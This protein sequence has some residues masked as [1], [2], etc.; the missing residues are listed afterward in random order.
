MQREREGR[1]PIRER[2]VVT[3]NICTKCHDPSQ[4]PR[5]ETTLPTPCPGLFCWE[6]AW[7]SPSHFARLLGEQGPRHQDLRQ[8]A[9][10]EGLDDLHSVHEE[11]QVLYQCQGI[12]AIHPSCRG[13]HLLRVCARDFIRQLHS[14]VLR[15]SELGVVRGVYTREGHSQLEEDPYIHPGEEVH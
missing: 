1:G 9:E 6:N 5:R 14:S 11:Q 15:D 8:A 13:G 2:C 3:P 4:E 7:L 10:G 12:R